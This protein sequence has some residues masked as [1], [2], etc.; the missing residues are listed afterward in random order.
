MLFKKLL[1]LI[2]FLNTMFLC[3]A[4]EKS[5]NKGFEL[6]SYKIRAYVPN[7]TTVH[8]SGMGG[9]W[10]LGSIELDLTNT[11]DDIWEGVV[12]PV[13]MG[14]HYY[15]LVVDGIMSLNPLDKV[16][17]ASG[18]YDN[19]IEIPDPDSGFYSLND[20]PHGTIR[21]HY[22]KYG[23]GNA[24]KVRRCLIYLPPGYDTKNETTYPVLYLQH[25]SGEHELSWWVQGKVNYI[26]DNLIAEGKA[27]PMI[28]VMENGMTA[29]YEWLFYSLQKEIESKYK[30]KTGKEN[31][32]VA[33]LSMGA[34]S[35][36]NLA[37]NS[38]NVIGYLGMFSSGA[39]IGSVTPDDLNS[40]LELVWIGWGNDDELFEGYPYIDAFLA[41][42]HVNST[43]TSFEGGHEWQVWRK[44]LLDFC[45]LLFKPYTYES[46]YVVDTENVP[47][48]CKLFPNPFSDRINLIIPDRTIDITRYCHLCDISGKT[49]LKFNATDRVAEDKL[50]SYLK[51]ASKGTYILNVSTK[52]STY[53]FKIIR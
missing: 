19:G 1:I 3:F 9:S 49:L 35:A 23:T 33:G 40:N 31:T 37:F 27:E 43:A 6:S 11:G 50:T 14:F 29:T 46:P 28:V 44:C 36:G 20:V 17:M 13:S 38:T 26:L 7:A 24:A 22:Y 48:N 30:V 12:S 39:A 41:P 52:S 18:Y 5:V 16:Y 45:S 32:A 51:N 10:G 8:V 21:M 4:Q 53:Q 34:S 47:I 25:G 42:F 2:L 15:I